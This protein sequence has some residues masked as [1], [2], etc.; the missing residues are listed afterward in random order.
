MMIDMTL[1]GVVGGSG[2][3]GGSI[4]RELSRK[5][6]VK[7]V[8]MREPAW[9]M[10]DYSVSFCRCDVR[11]FECVQECL[12]DVDI[13][14]HTAIIQIPMINEEKRLGF[15]VNYVGTMNVCEAVYRGPKARGLI[16]TGS[17]H[18]FGES[19]LIGVVDE[20]FGY[21][22]DKVEDRARLYVF[23]KIVQEVITRYYDEMSD[24]V[25]GIV[26]LGTVLGEG[27]PEKTAANIFIERGLRGEP[28]TPFKHSMY[29]PMLYVDV[30]DVVK[31]FDIYVNK[32]LNGEVEKHGSSLGRVLNLT[33]PEPITIIELAEAV[34][35]AIAELTNGKTVPKIE[36]VDQGLQPLFTEDSKYKF[37]VDISK[38]MKFLG[39]EKLI[40]P[41]KSI[42]DIVKSRLQ[43]AK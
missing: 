19:G 33:Y 30:R 42:Q 32:I 24:K 22:P 13:V 28:L 15:E 40:D 6:Y 17:W 26:R 14:I 1:I 10:K 37:K 41:R 8:D 36:I 20:S 9:N 39:V 23:S 27:M 29:R 25:Y 5:H 2:Y 16:L 31:S 35:D 34:R 38:T 7:I 18:V 12:R 43:R 11:I 4:A 3:I 21:R